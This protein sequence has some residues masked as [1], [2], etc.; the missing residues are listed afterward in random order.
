MVIMGVT[1]NSVTNIYIVTYIYI[2]KFK[3]YNF[4]KDKF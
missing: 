1:I 2:V 3:Y 4:K